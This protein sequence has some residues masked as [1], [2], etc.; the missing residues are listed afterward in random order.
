MRRQLPFPQRIT[1]S[2]I[3]LKAG[4]NE[5]NG[6]LCRRYD[7]KYDR[8]AA[9]HDFLPY[10]FHRRSYCDRLRRQ[11]NLE[12]LGNQN[13]S[14]TAISFSIRLDSHNAS[15]VAPTNHNPWRACQ[16]STK[17]RCQLTAPPASVPS[18]TIVA[19]GNSAF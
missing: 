9:G 13:K 18:A 14:P 16:F 3:G 17:A 12:R 6:P 4:C 5:K 15:P 10:G 8:Q 11:E 2:A 19:A 7:E 1:I